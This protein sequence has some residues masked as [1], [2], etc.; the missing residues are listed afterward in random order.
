[1]VAGAKQRVE[2]EFDYEY[3]TGRLRNTP[4]SFDVSVVY[5]RSGTPRFYGIGNNSPE[6]DVTNYT[7]QQ[8][9]VQT[10]VGWNLSHVLQIAYT[11]RVRDVEVQPG[12]LAG[13]ESLQGRFGAILGVGTN[14]ETL[15]RHQDHLRHARRYRSFRRAAVS[16]CSSAALPRRTAYSTPRCTA[17]TGVD[18]RQLWSPAPGNVI[19]AHMALRYMPGATDVP[20]WSLSNIGGEQERARRKPAAA[21]LRRGALL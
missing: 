2:S 7:L 8:K 14:H 15:N 12:T 10:T 17:S 11:L 20:F 18:A 1:M 9:Y 16:T 19:V 21:R 4:L 6:Y 3:Q 13:I 5:D